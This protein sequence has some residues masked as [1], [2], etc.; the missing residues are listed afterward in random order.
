VLL[1]LLTLPLSAPI[2]GIR[3]CL[4]KVAEVAEKEMWDEEPVREQLI[5]ENLAYEEGR[6]DEEAFRVREAELLARLREIKE[7]R[8]NMARES[9]R[10]QSDAQ[11]GTAV[12]ERRRAVI[13]LPDEV[14]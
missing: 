4:E 7:H 1:R 8:R 10:T 5:L 14:T 9:A 3:Y 11:A 13:D 6:L 12:D 2:A